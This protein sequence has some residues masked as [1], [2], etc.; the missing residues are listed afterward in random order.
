MTWHQVNTRRISM[1]MCAFWNDGLNKKQYQTFGIGVKNY[2]S[3]FD[4]KKTDYYV[5]KNDWDVYREGQRRLLDHEKWVRTIPWEAQNYLEMQLERF[6]REFPEDLAALS[7]DELLEL[8]QKV[9]EEV[10]WTNSRTW[11]IYLINDL[12]A[13]KVR[14]ELLKRLGDEEKVDQYLLSFSTPLEMNEAMNE[15]VA[16]LT[17]VRDRD[18]YSGAAFDKKIDEHTKRF[19]HIPMFGFDHKPFTKEHFLRV[20]DDIKDPEAELAELSGTMEKRKEV[21]LKELASLNLVHGDPLLHL[22]DMLKHTVFV[23]DYRDTLRQQMYLLDRYMY[24]EIGKRIGGLTAEQTTNF[25][26]KEI[27]HGLRGIHSSE[28]MQAIARE[29]EKAFLI[30]ER[31]YQQEV[32]SGDEAIRKAEEELGC[33]DLQ[34]ANEVAGIVGSKGRATG[35]ARIIQTNQDLHKVCEGDVMISQMT[36]QDFVPYMRKCAAI[37]TDEGGVTNHAA[38]VSR[39]FGMPCVVGT[40]TGTRVFT[41]GEMVEVD[42]VNGIVRKI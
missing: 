28:Q 3:Y 14:E 36:R 26:C 18:K 19:E 24:E 16:L 4:G 22:I 30:I 27:E 15:R 6:R 40:K 5:D 41:D 42:A 10:G 8:Q 23:R 7:N 9:K 13:E 39:E 11:M 33:M 2:L 1:Q 38:I 25:S 20:L 29:R 12:V 34:D 37:V 31:D 35:P 32:Y 17:L 21:F